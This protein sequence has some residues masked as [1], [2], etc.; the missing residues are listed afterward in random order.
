[1]LDEEQLNEELLKREALK[2]AMID[3]DYET[4]LSTEAGRRVFGGLFHACDLNSITLSESPAAM[5]YQ[6]GMRA[7]ALIVANRIR[8]IDP[9]LVGECDLA[10]S[11]FLRRCDGGKDDE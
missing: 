5:A 3:K 7:A 6:Q 9:R 10:W 8:Q 11:E 1:M 2:A 4:V